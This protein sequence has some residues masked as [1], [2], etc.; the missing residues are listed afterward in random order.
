MY[1]RDMLITTP[2]WHVLTAW[3]ACTET[4]V[5][6]EPPVEVFAAAHPVQY[7]YINL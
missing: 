5:A 6:E 7:L 1:M 4:A 2:I 3:S